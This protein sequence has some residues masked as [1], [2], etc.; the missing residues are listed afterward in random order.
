MNLN[1]NFDAYNTL[2]NPL[3]SFNDYVYDNLSATDNNNL[4][5]IQNSCICICLKA[6][7]TTPRSVLYA[8]SGIRPLAT[9]R[10]ENTAGI[11][12]LGLN[13]LSTPFVNSLFTKVE[14]NNHRVMRSEIKGDIVV[15]FVKLETVR[16]NIRYTGLCYYNKIGPEVR[17]AKT[18]KTF[19]RW[20]K[21]ESLFN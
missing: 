6:V 10:S 19:T 1:H 4:Q 15:P 14:G 16:G 18:C 2:I 11:V 8:E 3:F 7:R 13:K 9:Q 20:L 17:T 5:V 21:K 12:Y